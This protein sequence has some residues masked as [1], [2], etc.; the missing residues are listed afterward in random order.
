MSSLCTRAFDRTDSEDSDVHVLER[1]MIATKNIPSMHYP[2]RRNVTTSVVGL[3]KNNQ[4]NK[5]KK[6][7]GHICKQISPKMVKPRD[8]AGNTEEEEE[9]TG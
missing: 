7:P 2:R 1:W 6:N 8:L 4:T 5:T 3:K 9:K